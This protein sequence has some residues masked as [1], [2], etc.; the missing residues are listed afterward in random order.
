MLR[1]R[2]LADIELR[3]D[4]ASRALLP[5]DQP[6][7]LPPDRIGNGPERGVHRPNIGSDLY[8][9]QLKFDRP[10]HLGSSRYAG[11]ARLHRARAMSRRARALI[12]WLQFE[13]SAAADPAAL[14]ADLCAAAAGG[15]CAVCARRRSRSRRCIPW[16]PARPSS[17]RRDRAEALEMP[18]FHGMPGDAGFGPVP[19][20]A[21][22]AGPSIWTIAFSDGSRHTLI[23]ATDRPHGF[24]R[25]E[26]R[27]S[28]GGPRACWR[29][30]WRSW[31]PARPPRP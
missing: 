10:G 28:C 11:P 5:P 22:R 19:P 26:R 4:L 1:D 7:D 13:A 16:S 21:D 31:S 29:G 30:R 27:R 17:W 9:C 6:Q 25:A 23:L 20:P 8:K 15:G 12:E 3:A 2:G 18:R 24:D 14:L